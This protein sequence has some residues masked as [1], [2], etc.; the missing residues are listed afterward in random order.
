MKIVAETTGIIFSRLS[1]RK[2]GTPCQGHQGEIP[3]GEEER[4]ERHRS[5]D[6]ERLVSRG[7]GIADIKAVSAEAFPE[8]ERLGRI[9]LCWEFS[10]AKLK[11]IGHFSRT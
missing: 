6:P 9:G 8:N 2:A 1:G 3:G 7:T 10:G 5:S 11:E 4:H